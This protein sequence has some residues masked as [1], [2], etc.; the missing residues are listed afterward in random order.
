MYP[1][2]RAGAATSTNEIREKEEK[3][4]IFPMALHF[5][6]SQAAQI[7]ILSNKAFQLLWRTLELDLSTSLFQGFDAANLGFEISLLR[8]LSADEIPGH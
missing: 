1:E 7:V 3:T 6:G 4:A 2:G 5:P 8:E